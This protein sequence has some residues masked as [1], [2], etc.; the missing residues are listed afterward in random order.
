MASVVPYRR[1]ASAC[2]G[3]EGFVTQASVKLA[4]GRQEGFVCEEALSATSGA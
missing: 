1:L 4:T 3:E 2:T